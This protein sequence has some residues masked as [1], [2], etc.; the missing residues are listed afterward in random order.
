MG[1]EGMLRPNSTLLSV[2]EL[3]AVAP[4]KDKAI[5]QKEIVMVTFLVVRSSIFQRKRC[6]YSCW[7]KRSVLEK[8]LLSGAA[9]L[10]L[11][12]RRNKILTLFLN[13][14]MSGAW[15]QFYHVLG[16]SMFNSGAFIKSIP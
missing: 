4:A 15:I 12:C 5:M 10:S 9:L 2:K 3:V 6:L 7:L 11:E 13:R 1:A 14:C 16:L 8:M